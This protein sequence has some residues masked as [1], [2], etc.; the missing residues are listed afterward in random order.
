M[1]RSEWEATIK[2]ANVTHWSGLYLTAR[3]CTR[4]MCEC[5]SHSVR[6]CWFIVAPTTWP[7]RFTIFLHLRQFFLLSCCA[8]V[9]ESLLC[10]AAV[11]LRMVEYYVWIRRLTLYQY[12][13]SFRWCWPRFQFFPVPL[14]FLSVE[15]LFRLI[16]QSRSGIFAKVSS[17]IRII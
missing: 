1:R 11:C 16:S 4:A 10:Y 9:C 12:K 8:S 13:F 5:A 17:I 14:A 15:K 6:V 3:M 7:S 2:I